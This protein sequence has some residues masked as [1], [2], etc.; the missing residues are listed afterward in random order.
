MSKLGDS[1]AQLRIVLHDELAKQRRQILDELDKRL[2]QS[3]ED[4]SE[5][6]QGADDLSDDVAQSTREEQSTDEKSVEGKYDR[7][8]KPADE[9]SVDVKAARSELKNIADAC[10]TLEDKIQTC[11]VAIDRLKQQIDDSEGAQRD[12]L[13]EDMYSEMQDREKYKSELKNMR[14]RSNELEDQAGEDTEVENTVQSNVQE[15]TAEYTSDDQG[16]QDT[17]E[18]VSEDQNEQEPYSKPNEKAG[19][20]DTLLN[21]K[22]GLSKGFSAVTGAVGAVFNA[23]Q[24]FANKW[25]QWIPE[26]FLLLN[27]SYLAL[28]ILVKRAVQGVN[29]VRSKI[30]TFLGGADKEKDKE[31]LT[32]KEYEEKYGE[33]KNVNESVNQ[34]TQESVGKVFGKDESNKSSKDKSSTDKKAKSDVVEG[35]AQ[36][37]AARAQASVESTSQTA[38]EDLPISGPG[39]SLAQNN[40]VA[41]GSV[42]QQTAEVKDVA[43]VPKSESDMSLPSTSMQETEGGANGIVASNSI[44]SN[45]T[46]VNNTN[47]L[48]DTSVDYLG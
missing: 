19:M 32:D 12:K 27:L 1:L 3:I 23:V 25:F 28:K 45:V 39:I 47:Y 6:Q 33:P 5:D 41:E 22:G 4:Q 36:Q 9:Q 13:Q 10:I 37:E 2:E 30:P 17:T 44:N 42:Q 15:T 38:I 43:E 21:I 8:E 40:S 14:N 20:I 29:N 16:R 34:G 24:A 48:L 31:E 7:S 18:N 35:Q 46:I 26:I 11:N